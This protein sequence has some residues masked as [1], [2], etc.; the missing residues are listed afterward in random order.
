MHFSLEVVNIGRNDEYEPD[1]D[2]KLAAAI[3]HNH[4]LFKGSGVDYRVAFVEWNP[5]GNRPL[6]APTLLERFPY[7][8][9]VV[10]EPEVHARVCQAPGLELMLNFACNAALRTTSADFTLMTGGDDFFG[11]QLVRRIAE[12]GLREGVL[13]RAERVNVRRDLPFAAIDAATLEN[14]ANIVSIDSCTVPPYDKPPYTNACGDFM[15]L[16]SGTMSGIRGLDE[17]IDFA[18][19][20][21]DSRYCMTAMSVIED[22]VLLGRVFHIDHA[23]S[24]KNKPR[25][26]GR[27]YTWEAGLPYVNGENWGLADFAWTSGNDRL[28]RVRVPAAGVATPI[29]EGLKP[30]QRL[31][32]QMVASRLAE[33]HT[34]L[35]PEVPP[36]TEPSETT[37][38]GEPYVAREWDTALDRVPD[39]LRIETGSKQWDYAAGFSLPESISLGDDRW[40][41][42]ALSLRLEEGCIGVGF[43]DPSGAFVDERLFQSP[44]DGT[45]YVPLPGGATHAVLR[46]A[47]QG[48]RSILVLR[49]AAI[50]GIPR[51]TTAGTSRV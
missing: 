32:A 42:L 49:G 38:L 30:T 40:R 24:L 34:A 51:S 29:P 20:H 1:W 4:G 14:P 13:Y 25:V 45:V 28:L 50:V 11:T 8:R 31:R 39:G 37:P 33:L 46:N 2:R 5:P 44:A 48:D 7:L 18:R 6:L 3:E 12:D 21:L 36:G 47:A 16:D 41:W 17:S 23:R 9:C 26:P 10:V 27:A 43:I 15:L 19:L 35:Q 22:C